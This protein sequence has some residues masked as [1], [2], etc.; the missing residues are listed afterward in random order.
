MSRSAS[1]SWLWIIIVTQTTQSVTTNCGTKKWD[2]ALDWFLGWKI[3]LA[4]DG[5]LYSVSLWNRYLLM[6]VKHEHWL[7][8]E[9]TSAS[10]T[11]LSDILNT[12]TSLHIYARRGLSAVNKWLQWLSLSLSRPAVSAPI[13]RWLGPSLPGTTGSWS[14]TRDPGHRA[15]YNPASDCVHWLYT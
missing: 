1:T 7:G 8:D 10:W 2:G 3:T 5:A 13:C 4:L 9:N 15:L 6:G 12:R 11:G 14:V